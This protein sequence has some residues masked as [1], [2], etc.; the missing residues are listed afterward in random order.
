MGK[1]TAITYARQGAKVLAWDLGVDVEG[2]SLQNNPVDE[3]VEI[4]KKVGAVP[5]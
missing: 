2:R 4:I 3:T 1:A 5:L